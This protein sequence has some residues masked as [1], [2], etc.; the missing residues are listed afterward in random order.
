M[1]K[2][3]DA[4]RTI[5][6]VAKWLGTQTHV[7]RFWESK[8]SQIDPVKRAGGRRYYRPDD[9]Q[10]I[11]GI[12]QLLHEDGMTIKGVQ[13]L[14]SNKGVDHVRALSPPLDFIE[15]T[16]APKIG[17][18]TGRGKAPKAPRSGDSKN[19]IV[20]FTMNPLPKKAQPKTSPLNDPNQPLLFPEISEWSPESDKKHSAKIITPNIRDIPSSSIRPRRPIVYADDRALDAFAP[21]P[22]AISRVLRMTPRQRAAF[23]QSNQAQLRQMYDYFVQSNA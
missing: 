7:L 15:N 12:K 13:K 5:S 14:L 3:P 6:E 17:P 20:A 19:N 2:S 16:P 23:V 22:A 21:G 4:F 8:F 18:K 1:A 10:L 11:G 9:M